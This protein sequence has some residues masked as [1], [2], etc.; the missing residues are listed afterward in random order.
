MN[1]NL[2]PIILRFLDRIMVSQN[3]IWLTLKDDFGVV[4]FSIYER[5]MVYFLSFLDFEFD[6]KLTWYEH[7]SSV[8]SMI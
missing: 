2:E 3:S 7:L 5:G 8:W 1:Q 6:D 4:Y